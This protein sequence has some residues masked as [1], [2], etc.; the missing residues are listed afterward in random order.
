MIFS[1]IYYTLLAVIGK[2]DMATIP[3]ELQTEEMCLAV[4]KNDGMALRYVISQT[5]KICLAAVK[6][7]WNALEYVKNQTDEICSYALS[8]S[9]LALMYIKSDTDSIKIN[10]IKDFL[11]WDRAL[12]SP[13][14]PSVNGD[15]DGDNNAFL[16]IYKFLSKLDDDEL[17]RAISVDLSLF[18][19]EGDKLL[20]YKGIRELKDKAVMLE[21]IGGGESKA[22]IIKKNR[23]I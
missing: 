11:S 6:N 16:N 12:L 15:G 13:C 20:S 1:K 14:N 5:D 7:N 10:H 2:A 22:E 9:Y 17:V 18:L 4:V 23:V 8:E 3:A 19:K 21:L